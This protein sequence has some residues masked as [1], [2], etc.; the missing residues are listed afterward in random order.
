ML[1]FFNLSIHAFLDVK[2]REKRESRSKC[3][4]RHMTLFYWLTEHMFKSNN[5]TFNYLLIC[6]MLFSFVRNWFLKY[7]VNR[8]TNCVHQVWETKLISPVPLYRWKNIKGIA[9]LFGLTS[10]SLYPKL[11]RLEILTTFWVQLN[12]F[13]LTAE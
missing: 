13:C 12:I 1:T 7:A 3:L 6:V 4:L 2:E 8:G 9:C 5:F 11:K 10:D